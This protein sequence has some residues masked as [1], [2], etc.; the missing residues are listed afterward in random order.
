[1]AMAERSGLV[2]VLVQ[3]FRQL[4]G[5]KN[6]LPLCPVSVAPISAQQPFAL[7]IGVTNNHVAGAGPPTTLLAQREQAPRCLIRRRK[8]RRDGDAWLEKQ[9]H[10]RQRVVHGDEV[11]VGH[12]R[13]TAS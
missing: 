12:P 8:R 6:E 2:S 7:D 13:R 9:R 5:V 4:P 3:F 10:V 1:M 11:H